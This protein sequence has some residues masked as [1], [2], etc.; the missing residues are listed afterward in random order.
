MTIRTWANKVEFIEMIWIELKTKMTPKYSLMIEFLRCLSE[1][2]IG[3]NLFQAYNL[4][5]IDV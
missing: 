4:I 2:H 1:M 5:K 3:V